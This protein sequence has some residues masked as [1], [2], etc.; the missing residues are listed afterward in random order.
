MQPLDLDATQDARTSLDLVRRT[1]RVDRT[2]GIVLAAY[3]FYALSTGQVPALTDIL[4][5]HPVLGNAAV[6]WLAVHL[7]T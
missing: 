2:I 6:G 3:E 4:R 1:M 7:L 5:Q